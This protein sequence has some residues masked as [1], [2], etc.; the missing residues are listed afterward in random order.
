MKNSNVLDTLIRAAVIASAVLWLGCQDTSQRGPGSHPTT[1]NGH[2]PGGDFTGTG[3]G[4]GGGNGVNG[5]VYEAYIVDPSTLK[6]YN[7]FVA[8]ILQ[9]LELT[10]MYKAKTWYIAP[11]KFKPLSKD[12]LGLAFTA[13]ETE[14]LAVQT[15]REIWI[16]SEAFEKMSGEEQ[17]KL[18]LHEILMSTYFLKFKNSREW[19]EV[20]V[21][22]GGTFDGRRDC[23]EMSDLPAIEPESPLQE[24]DYANIR[25]MTGWIWENYK[26][27]SKDEAYQQFVLNDFGTRMFGHFQEHQEQV[28]YPKSELGELLSNTSLLG[29]MPTQCRGL[30]LGTQ[31]DCSISLS[32]VKIPVG[33]GFELGGVQMD[34]R[35]E[36]GVVI[37]SQQFFT[38][39]GNQYENSEYDPITKQKLFFT[40]VVERPLQNAKRGDRTRNLLLFYTKSGDKKEIYALLFVPVVV[41]KVEKKNDQTTCWTDKPK[42]TNSANDI[43]AVVNPETDSKYLRYFGNVIDMQGIACN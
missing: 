30:R 6:A 33:L 21:K 20:F 25:G 10:F 36:T 1:S 39:G 9:K 24:N 38:Q 8:P 16:N 12:V 14:Q 22:M 19:C 11:H 32:D 5:K 26:L 23:T 13:D 35:D 18:I 4:G 7:D 29:K 3:D 42:S 34:I 2:L 28:T 43:L 41:T 15:S 37:L 31:V 40:V 17:G 27:S